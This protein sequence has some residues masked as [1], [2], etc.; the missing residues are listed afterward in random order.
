MKTITSYFIKADAWQLCLMM[1]APYGIYKLTDF[2]HSPTSRGVLMIYFL[3]VALGWIYSIG[4]S[5]NNKLDTHLQINPV[6]FRTALILPFIC[7]LVFIFL[8]LIPLYRGE[9]L[10]PPRW[11][12]YINFAGI[13]SFVY[14]IWYA[15]KQFSTLRLNRETVFI[16]YY[17]AFMA[18][19]FGFVGVWF[20]QPRV[21]R[22]LGT[23]Q[24]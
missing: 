15:A 18:L 11:G 4:I 24:P 19:W 1:V 22:L 17:A 21:R 10:Y 9:I 14:S 16:D 20:L 2:G 23:E 5:S 13:I 7:L 8:I 6:V 12:I 3:L